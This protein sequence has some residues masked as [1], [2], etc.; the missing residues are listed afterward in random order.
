MAETVAVKPE[1]LHWAIERS[2]LP[3]DDLAA[4]FPKLEQWLNGERLPTHKQ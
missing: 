2:L 1:M 4:T 3:A